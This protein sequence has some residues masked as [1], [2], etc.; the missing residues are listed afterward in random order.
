MSTSIQLQSEIEVFEQLI[1]AYPTPKHITQGL[2]FSLSQVSTL[3]LHLLF[4]KE[5]PPIRKISGQNI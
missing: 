3:H 5:R 1:V 4:I 2:L